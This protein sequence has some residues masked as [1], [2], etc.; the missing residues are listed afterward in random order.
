M[1][2]ALFG[3]GQTGQAIAYLLRKLDLSI[4]EIRGFDCRST[5]S[6]LVD[7]YQ[8]FDMSNLGIFD[9]FANYKPD[10]VLS[11]LP[12]YCNHQLAQRAIQ[13]GIPYYDL[14]GSIEAARHIHKE[15]YQAKHARVFTDLGLA[16]GWVNIMAEEAYQALPQCHT[17]KMY[18]GG[19]PLY[20]ASHYDPF[21]YSLTWSAAGLYNEYTDTTPILIDGKMEYVAPLKGVEHLNLNEHNEYEAFFTSGGAASTLKLMAD[22]GVK[23]CFYKTIRYMGHA[24]LIRYFI[25]KG[26]DDRSLADLFIDHPEGDYVI[27]HV[28]AEADNLTY[29]KTR[30]I[31]PTDQFSAM[32]LGTAGGFIAAAMSCAKH[33]SPVL[34]YSDVDLTNFNRIIRSLGLCKEEDF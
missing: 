6:V 31:E 23:N 32:Q 30:I 13:H 11:A 24:R 1:R 14:G 33:E 17:I 22:R 7:Q 4:E 29:K 16:P 27:L 28:V 25:D 26:F 9:P 34:N 2:V 18:C 10:I 5:G 15:A 21:G 20:R 19:L 12:Y 3:L 8:Y